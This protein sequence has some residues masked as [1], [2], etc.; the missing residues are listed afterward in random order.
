MKNTTEALLKF[1]AKLLFSR[2]GYEG[3]SMRIL[4]KESGVGL[5]SM[6][7]FFKD[8]DQILHQVFDDTRRQLGK[9]RATLFTPATASDMLRQRIIFQF[10]HIDDVIFI[11][12]YY[13]H[14]RDYIATSKSSYSTENS[15]KHI[16]EV[17]E[18]GLET[19]EFKLYEDTVDEQ[20]KVITH[21]I[22]GFL[23][24]CY[25][26]P[27]RGTE[28]SKVVESIHSFLIRSLKP[29]EVPMS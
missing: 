7:H 23:L 21:A 2:V 18:R 1:H 12:K 11:L 24:E 16:K 26:Y 3:F 4:S 13:L 9:E 8:K 10:H 25:P 29:A 28:L 17:L 6:Y 19:K 22:N 20:A 14:F 5:S 15:Y 27:P